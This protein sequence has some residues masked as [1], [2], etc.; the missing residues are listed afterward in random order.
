M[1]P[2]FGE[3]IVRCRKRAEISQAEL[4]EQ[5]GLSRNYVSLI[6]RD[7]APNLSVRKMVALFDVLDIDA[8]FWGP[9]IQCYV[10][11]R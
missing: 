1:S 7:R 5:A 3:L 2:T 10:E 11:V 6:E 4:A 9:C 8:A